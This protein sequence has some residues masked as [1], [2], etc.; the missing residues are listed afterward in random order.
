MY[1]WLSLDYVVMGEL[2]K[3]VLG[4][5]VALARIFHGSVLRNSKVI[6]HEGTNG[7]HCHLRKERKINA[8]WRVVVIIIWPLSKSESRLVYD[9]VGGCCFITLFR[10]IT[11]LCGINNVSHNIPHILVGLKPSWFIFNLNSLFSFL[12]FEIDFNSLSVQ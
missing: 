7:Q 6:M 10:S 1:L 4:S 8:T 12:D 5:I 11:M 3:D 9:L 2:S